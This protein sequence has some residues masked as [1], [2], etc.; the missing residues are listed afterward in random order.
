MLQLDVARLEERNASSKNMPYKRF[1]HQYEFP[2]AVPADITASLAPR[3]APQRRPLHTRDAEQNKTKQT[4]ICQQPYM[5]NCRR[6]HT[7]ERAGSI[8]DDSVQGRDGCVGWGGYVGRGWW[9]WWNDVRDIETRSKESQSE[10]VNME[11]VSTVLS[12]TSLTLI[13][14]FN[15]FLSF[16]NLSM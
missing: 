14:S 8:S 7:I 1:G 4:S 13:F 2:Q 16:L 9:W 15:I 10:S 5:C 12:A 6:Q 11:Q 3:V